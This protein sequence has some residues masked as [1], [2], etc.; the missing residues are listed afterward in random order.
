VLQIVAV[1][2]ILLQCVAVCCSVLQ[3]VIDSVSHDTRNGHLFSSM[4]RICMTISTEML[5]PQN[6]PNRE[7]Q[8]PR[9][10]A[11]QIQIQILI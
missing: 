9:Y 4:D 7:A 5:H 10:L 8:I 2:C 1:C 3:C 11:V 6:L